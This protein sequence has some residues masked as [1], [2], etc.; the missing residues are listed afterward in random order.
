MFTIENYIMVDSLDEAYELNQSRSNVILGGIMWL[1]M[2]NR[3]IENA[4]DL[5]SLGLNTIEEDDESFKI[6][7][8][9]TLRELEVHER[10]NT[11]FNGILRKSV[12]HIVGVQ[13][14]NGATI[15]GTIFSRFGFS[16]VLT[17]LLAL[18]TYVELYKGGIVSLEDFIAM[19]TDNDILIRIIIKKDNRKV[20]YSTLRKSST[21][22]PVLACAVSYAEDTWKAVLGARPGTAKAVEI[23]A[24]KNIA[25]EEITAF[26]EK[27]K[28]TIT[29]GSNHLGSK[30]Y[31]S[32]LADVLVRRN[33]EEI[34]E[35]STYED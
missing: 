25:I 2:S 35:G 15:G 30:E 1:K 16:D 4:I 28:E 12:E 27:I 8:M 29:F 11:E 9:C 10:L 26:I 34:I 13:L 24:S 33:I 3:K 5:S 31:R 17:A 19:R 6:G 22:F 23:K 14:R 32:I 7:C 21:D 18:D 20:S